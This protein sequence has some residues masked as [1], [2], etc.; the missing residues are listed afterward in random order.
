MQRRPTGRGAVLCVELCR[1]RAFPSD[2]SRGRCCCFSLGILAAPSYP[3][4][5]PASPFGKPRSLLTLAWV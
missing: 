1:L 4:H 5:G 3:C 2:Q